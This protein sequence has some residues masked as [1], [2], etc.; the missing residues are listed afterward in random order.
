MIAL[1]LAPLIM[2]FTLQNIVLSNHVPL[3]YPVGRLQR[4]YRGIEPTPTR[5]ASPSRDLIIHDALGTISRLFTAWYGTMVH[6]QAYKTPQEWIDALKLSQHRSGG[7]S[8][9]LIAWGV[10]RSESQARQVLIGV[11]VIACA[12]ALFAMRSMFS[13]PDTAMDQESAA[14]LAK[15]LEMTP[16]MPGEPPR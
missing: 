12:V 4:C 2:H 14:Q 1:V 13:P 8:N 11:F 9:R 3:G 5:D 7:L 6:M 10:A 15:M 16:S